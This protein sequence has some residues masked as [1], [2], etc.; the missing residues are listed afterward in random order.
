MWWGI[1]II[2]NLILCKETLF[3]ASG[4]M[5]N[6]TTRRI[7]DNNSEYPV[8]NHD[9]CEFTCAMNSGYCACDHGMS[10][11]QIALFLTLMC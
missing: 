2:F 6:R 7:A 10:E 4:I 8:C 3:F 9:L 5:K 1:Q 11:I